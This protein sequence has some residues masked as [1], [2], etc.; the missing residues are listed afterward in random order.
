M[1]ASFQPLA[2]F[3]LLTVC[4]RALPAQP[5]RQMPLKPANATLNADFVGI[6]SMREI[7]DGRVIVTDGRDQQLYLADFRGNNASILGRKGTGPG[8]W[9]NVGF[10]QALFGD[11]SILG[12]FGNRRLLLFDGARIVGLVPL[13]HPTT[14]ISLGSVWGAD[15]FGH[16]LGRKENPADATRLVFTRADSSALVLIDRSNGALDTVTR[17]RQRPRRAEQIAG[18]DGKARGRMVSPSEPNAQEEIAHLFAD[19]WIAVV[20]LEPLRVDWRS[21]ERRWTHGAPFRLKPIPVDDRER[22]AIETRRAQSREE[23]R[24][25][26]TPE[27]RL[28]SLPSSI[29]VMAVSIVLRATPDGR[30]II[31]RSTSEA[32]PAVRYLVVNRRGDIDGEIALGAREDVIGF[33]PRSIYVAFNDDDDIQRIRRH[34]WP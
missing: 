27:Q 18:A 28:P 9:L 8:E 11:S 6:T 1:R 10:V 3:I 23:F 5:V 24:K 30:L 2:W 22:Q 14:S 26:G 19:G 32:D 13:D 29:P 25:M 17:V 33:G 7:A 12:D 20:R 15:R 31:R 16:L 4:A 34:P 21:R